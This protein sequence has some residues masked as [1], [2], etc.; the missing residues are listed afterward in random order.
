MKKIIY[1]DM[2]NVLVDFKTGIDKLD[3]NIIHEYEGRLDEVPNI[4]SLMEPY[5]NAIRSVQELSDK[6]DLYILST[7]PWLNPS[8]WINKIEWV[9]KHFGKEENSLFYKRLIISHN[10]NLNSGDYLI[11]DRPNNG[12]KDFKGEWIH[13]GSQEFPNWDKV[14]DYLI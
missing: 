9:H 2:D 12:A 6:Y 7:A 13:F 14:I 1:I 8:A 10:K 11:D 5:P 3:K 4:F